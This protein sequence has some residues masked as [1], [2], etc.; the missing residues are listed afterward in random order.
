MDGFPAV[1]APQPFAAAFFEKSEWDQ[2]S[3]EEELEAPSFLESA[4]ASAFCC[5]ASSV[6]E[7]QR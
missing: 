2:G 7:S 6:D 1:G 5:S 4:F 3:D